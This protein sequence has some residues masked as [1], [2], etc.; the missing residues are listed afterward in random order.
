M[1]LRFVQY[2]HGR[3]GE[4][5]YAHNGTGSSDQFA[6]PR[7]RDRITV[8]NSAQSNLQRERAA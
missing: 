5:G 8:S 7:L 2:T 4:E 1:I 6:N 3:Q